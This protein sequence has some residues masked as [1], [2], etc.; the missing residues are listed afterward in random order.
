M[1]KNWSLY[2]VFCKK[3]I[4]WSFLLD[5]MW[6]DVK[7][8]LIFFMSMS[9]NR[10]VWNWKLSFASTSNSSFDSTSKFTLS[11]LQISLLIRHP[12][13]HL[14]W[15]LTLHWLH[16]QLIYLF[17]NFLKKNCTA[18]I[19]I[20]YNSN[21]YSFTPQIVLFSSIIIFYLHHSP[22]KW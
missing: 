5:W 17:K 10:L 12:A 21:I 16:Y 14:F 2:E 1:N 6:H 9:L 8:I 22:P 7:W 13:H 18:S 3:I 19:S 20:D 11:R 15:Y 4:I